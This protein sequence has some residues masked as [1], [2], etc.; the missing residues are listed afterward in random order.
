MAHKKVS[1][2]DGKTAPTLNVER[3]RLEK[4]AFSGFAHD[5]KTPLACIIGAL[6]IYGRMDEKLTPEKRR[7]LIN[8]ALQEAHKL[9]GFISTLLDGVEP[10]NAQSHTP[11]E[12]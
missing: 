4:C 7:L 11:C 1:H 5:L 2:L 8:T 9:N 12:V 10:Q 6:E 3:E